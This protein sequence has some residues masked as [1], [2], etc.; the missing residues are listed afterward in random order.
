[1]Q[2]R[3]FTAHRCILKAYSEGVH[4]RLYVPDAAVTP[5]RCRG[6]C[7]SFIQFNLRGQAKSS[8]K[9]TVVQF[10]KHILGGTQTFL[11]LFA[12]SFLVIRA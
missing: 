2:I 9:P 1:M 12:I 3:R 8:T 7:G 6:I 10:Y 4:Q 5:T 11:S